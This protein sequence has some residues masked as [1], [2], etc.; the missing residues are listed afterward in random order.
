MARHR[1]IYEISFRHVVDVDGGPGMP[2][3]GA[4]AAAASYLAQQLSLMDWEDLFCHAHEVVPVDGAA[5]DAAEVALPDW[6][7]PQAV[8]VPLDDPRIGRAFEFH[9]DDPAGR[10]EG[11][12]RLG[13][14]QSEARR[15]N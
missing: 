13:S 14:S 2:R 6:P 5:D 9:P 8:I 10:G 4:R 7:P 12:I 3:S 11:Y 15:I 1:F